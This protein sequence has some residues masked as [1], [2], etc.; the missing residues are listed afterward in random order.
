MSDLKSLPP[1]DAPLDP[2]AQSLAK[3]EPAPARLDRDRLMFAAGAES[4]RATIRLWQATAG[5][6]AAVGFAAG[7][8]MKPASIVYVDRDPP[9]AKV[10]P[11]DDKK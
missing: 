3:L 6:L 5:F 1:P 8:L 11:A 4:R 7:M 9:P 10:S 2:V